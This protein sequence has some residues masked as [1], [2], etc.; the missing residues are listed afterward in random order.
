MT[1]ATALVTLGLEAMPNNLRELQ[2]QV[3]GTMH[4]KLWS[5]DQTRAYQQLQAH[6]QAN[7]SKPHK[8]GCNGRP[9]SPSIKPK[10]RNSKGSQHPTTEGRSP[11]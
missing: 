11:R 9:V 2:H 3:A 1:P 8:S 4:P 7:G 10:R 5:W 6:I